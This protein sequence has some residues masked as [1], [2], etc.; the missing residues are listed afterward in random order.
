MKIRLLLLWLLLAITAGASAQETPA[1]ILFVGVKNESSDIYLWQPDGSEGVVTALTQT[2]QKEGNACW[3]PRKGL[4]LASRELSENH[5]GLVAMN[6]KLETVWQLEDPLG[7]L[8]WPVPSPWD[9]RIL[10][11]RGMSDGFVQTGVLSFP[12]GSFEPFEFDGLAGGQLSWLAEDRIMLSRVTAA[13]FALTHR[14]LNSGAEEVITSGGQNWQSHVNQQTGRMFFVRRAGQISSIFELF[15][16]AQNRWQYENLTNARTYDWQPATSP[17][18]RTL[19]YRSLRDGRF[20]T[21]IR[22]LAG[23]AEK[24][25]DLGDFAQVFFPTILERADVERLIAGRE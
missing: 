11:V 10:C 13:G 7:S 4:I 19:I 21:V 18:G 12:D 5:Y 24:R 14:D 3:W 17:D 6:E 25:I 23:G 15:K 1:G 8:G 22:D 2:P 9:D 20:A 16:D